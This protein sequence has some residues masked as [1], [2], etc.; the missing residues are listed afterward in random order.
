MADSDEQNAVILSFIKRHKI[1]VIATADLKGNPEAAV[2][3]FA[4]T[5]NLEL[6]FDTFITSRKYRNLKLNSKIAFVI[7]WDENKTVQYEGEAIELEGSELDV[8]K[9]IFFRRNPRAKKWDGREGIV[10][11]KVKPKWI[12]YSDLAVDPWYILEVDFS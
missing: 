7:G 10:Y 1:G 12:R 5:D 11:F 6:I 9:Q 8:C 4:E 3:E 2:V